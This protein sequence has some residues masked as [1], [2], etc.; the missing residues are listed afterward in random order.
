MMNA[1]LTLISQRQGLDPQE[2]YA[3]ASKREGRQLDVMD[4]I[5]DWDLSYHVACALKYMA[6]AGGYGTRD[7]KEAVGHLERRIQQLEQK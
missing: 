5:F 7:L 4:V 2:I 1:P 3:S 6:N